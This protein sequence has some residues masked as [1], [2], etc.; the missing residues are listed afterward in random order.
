VA[1]VDIDG[2]IVVGVVADAAVDPDALLPVVSATVAPL[3][4]PHEIRPVTE[5]PR[6]AAGKVRRDAL[7]ELLTERADGR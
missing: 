3:N 7:R 6:N 1:A 5:I 2:R 4:V